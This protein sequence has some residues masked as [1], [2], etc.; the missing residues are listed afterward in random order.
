MWTI[1]TGDVSQQW[2]IREVTSGLPT[3]RET[4]YAVRWLSE[5]R[6]VSGKECWE[7]ADRRRENTG[8]N[9]CMWKIYLLLLFII[10]SHFY[11]GSMCLMRRL[12]LARSCVSSLDNS[13][14]DKSFLMLSNHLRFGLPLLLFPGTSIAITHLPTYSSSQY[15]PIPLQPTWDEK[16]II[17]EYEI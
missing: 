14:S 11:V 10:F 16:N 17:V 2:R 5:H 1:V 9:A 8:S 7:W 12:H 3:D 15:V 4:G 13:L 6:P